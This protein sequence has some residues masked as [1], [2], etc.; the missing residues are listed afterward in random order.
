[1]RREGHTVASFKLKRLASLVG[2][3]FL[4]IPDNVKVG[5]GAVDYLLG[6]SDNVRA[7][8]HPLA[9]LNPVQRCTTLAAI[10]SF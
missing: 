2:I 4:S 7:K 9:K 10:Q 5:L 8:D 6:L 3:P 1:V